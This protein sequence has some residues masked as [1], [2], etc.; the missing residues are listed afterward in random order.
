MAI[1]AVAGSISGIIG[2]VK[3][4]FESIG[5]RIK[6]ATKHLTYD[7]AMTVANSF[8]GASIKFFHDNYSV[9]DL[10]KVMPLIKNKWIGAM[11]TQ[12]GL[13]GINASIAHDLEN[14]EVRTDGIEHMAQSF[15]LWCAI[16]SDAGRPDDFETVFKHYW[17]ALFVSSFSQVGL[18]TAAIEA[19]VGTAI[20]GYGGQAG[21]S[22]SGGSTGSGDTG[23][24]SFNVTVPINTGTPQVNLG[25]GTSVAVAGMEPKTIALVIGAA[26]L[27]SIITKKK[28]G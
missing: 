2:T 13:S 20:A 14:F 23:G 17:N 8:G 9:T 19:Q 3:G 24:G 26:I 22:G 10:L 18:P 25:P 6:G 16:N 15:A 7:Q 11:S 1:L 27:L 28:G 21:G 4:V 5:I 12:W